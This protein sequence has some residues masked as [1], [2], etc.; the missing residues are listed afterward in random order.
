VW[1]FN[2]KAQCDIGGVTKRY[3]GHEAAGR[4]YDCYRHAPFDTLIGFRNYY[5]RL[6]NSQLL[7]IF[8]IRPTYLRVTHDGSAQMPTSRG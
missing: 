6:A 8:V 2:I 7:P 4:E 3:M 1:H 5:E